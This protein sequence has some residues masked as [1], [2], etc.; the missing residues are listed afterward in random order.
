VTLSCAWLRSVGGVEELVFATDSRLRGPFVW[1]A[2]PKVLPLPR[3]DCALCFAGDTAVAYPIM[4]Q[5]EAAVRY[6]SR[7]LNR[8][9]DLTE[10]R[11][12]V[13]DLINGMRLA[14]HSFPKLEEGHIEDETFLVL[15]GYS[16]RFSDFRI[17]TLHYDAS[18]GRFTFR[19]ASAWSGIDGNRLLAVVGNEVEYAKKRLIDL[20]TARG[21]REVGGFDMEPFEVLRD[22]IRSEVHD[23]IGGPPQLLK[24]YRHMNAT[25]F[26][27]YWPDRA[28]GRVTMLGRELLHYERSSVGILD[29]DSLAVDSPAA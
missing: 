6:Y 12:K 4:L 3:N 29:P 27:V 16:W 28:S 14:M 11:G 23:S 13:L 26:S 19:P 10:F 1:D 7:T 15:G 9:V 20:L 8:A 5:L 25:P 17:W 18:I 22:I 2:C 21:K 24:V